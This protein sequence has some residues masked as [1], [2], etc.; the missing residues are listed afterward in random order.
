MRNGIG[1]SE[2]AGGIFWDCRW[3]HARGDMHMDCSASA[4]IVVRLRKLQTHVTAAKAM[5]REPEYSVGLR[6]GLAEGIQSISPRE[7]HKASPESFGVNDTE[8]PRGHSAF[9]RSE[10]SRQCGALVITSRDIA[11]RQNQSR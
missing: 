9:V 1:G 7:A 10:G 8:R 2:L 4:A 6:H 3:M 5:L 11:V